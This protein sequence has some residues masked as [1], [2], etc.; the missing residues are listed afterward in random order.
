MAI[1]GFLPQDTKVVIGVGVRAIVASPISKSLVSGMAG[2]VNAADLLK[3]TAAAGFN[4]L[5]DVDDV[6]IAT[7][8][9]GENPPALI[10]AHGRFDRIQVEGGS[11]Y[12]GV[13]I[14][15]AGDKKDSAWAVLDPATAV[16]GDPA[17]VRRAIDRRTAASQL[18]PAVMTILNALRTQYDIW[19][20][21]QV[22]PAMLPDAAK[23]QGLDAVDRFQFGVNVS[24][25]L[26]LSATLHMRSNEDGEKLAAGAR[27]LEAMVRAQ[28]PSM[29]KTQLDIRTENQMVKIALS[30]PQE[31]IDKA[32]EARMHPG[33]VAPA[34]AQAPPRPAGIQ[35]RAD[36]DTMVLTLP[37][38]RQ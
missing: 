29:G 23:Q 32:I 10:V 22:N 14:H 18:D 21:G 26:Q 28:Q 8:G 13:Q 12:H 20:Y 3:L 19:G 31:E 36:G 6:L 1:P 15:V 11:M 5:A 30:V 7:N 33:S 38:A 17:L 16:A 37:G 35:K 2:N 9:K 34:R 24:S 4:P 25:G 27:L